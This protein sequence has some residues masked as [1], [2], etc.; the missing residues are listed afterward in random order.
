MQQRLPI[1]LSITALVVAVLAWTSVGE[2]AKG[3]I[4]GK[5]SRTGRFEASM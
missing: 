2:A 3:L 5:T 1:V 4:T